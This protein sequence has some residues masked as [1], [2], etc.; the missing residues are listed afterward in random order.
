MSGPRGPVAPPGSREDIL[1]RI[2][3]LLG[4][5]SGI[6]GVWRN[7]GDFTNPELPV[8]VLLDGE[9]ELDPSEDI[10]RMK[11]GRMPS[12]RMILKPDI[13]I[14]ARQRDTVSNQTLAG[15]PAPIGPELSSWRDKVLAAVINDQTL[16]SLLTPT[17]QIVYRG[18]ETDMQFGGSLLGRLLLHIEFTYVWAA[19]TA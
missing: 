11:F 9:E 1:A 16:L 8:A 18:C 6:G 7:R 15:S 17:G 5:I 12:A 4:S 19:P 3:A 14:I 10:Q 2:E 13:L